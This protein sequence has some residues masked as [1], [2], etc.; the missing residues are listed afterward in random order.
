MINKATWQAK[1]QNNRQ[2]GKNRAICARRIFI[3]AK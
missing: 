3:P 1:Q 2:I